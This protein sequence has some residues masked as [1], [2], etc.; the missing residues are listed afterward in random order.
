[1][2]SQCTENT[3]VNTVKRFLADLRY[4][5]Q[6]FAADG[7]AVSLL[8]VLVCDGSGAVFWYRAM[9]FFARRSIT[10]PL[11]LLCQYLNKLL[12]QCVIGLKVDFDD[13]LVLMHPVGIV[14]NSKVRGGRR[15]VIESG[16]VIGDEKGR[17]PVLESDIFIGAG[18]KIIGGLT[19]ASFSKIGANAVVVKDVAKATT[20][21]GIPAKPISRVTD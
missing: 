20:V 14:I 9:Q 15:I 16:V 10:L 8:K 19:I 17:S 2:D 6:V 4:K 5:Q 21:V 1:M 12:N 7:A 13:E 11:A 3:G 18:A